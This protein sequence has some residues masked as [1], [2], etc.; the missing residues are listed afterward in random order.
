[1]DSL[2]EGLISPALFDALADALLL[3]DEAGYVI[4]SNPAAQKFLG[5]TAEQIY[6]LEVETLMPERFRS[7]HYQHREN[8]F[9]RPVKH[10][11]G[12]GKG[13]VAL[14]RDGEEKPM[15]ISLTPLQVKGQACVLITLFD[16]SLRQQ[17]EN[18]LRISEERLEGIMYHM[19]E[20][21]VTEQKQRHR[22]GELDALRS[23]QVAIQTATAIAHELNQ[24]LAAVS[25]YS[26]VA[27]H[28]LANLD[29]SENLRRALQGSAEQAQRAGKTLHE[30]LE[31]LH[32]G[33]FNGDLA[34]APIDMNEMVRDA[35]AAV[36]HDSH[37]GF[38][39]V[40]QL[41]H[42]LPAVMA[43]RIQVQ[44]I[45]T[46]LIHNGVEAARNA[47]MSVSTAMIRVQTDSKSGMA[48]ITVQDNG[49][50]LDA[51]MASKI[52]T[53]FFTT[54][55]RGIG[56][57]LAVSHALAKANGGKLWASPVAGPGATFYLTLPFAS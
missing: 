22:R 41:K 13:M 17:T 24:P 9:I 52:F 53:P 40:L 18:A 45:L 39:P 1:M 57:G 33:D 32:Q 19:T 30:L 20:R 21:R 36:Q 5:Y 28:E 27:L 16:A 12:C 7:I 31:F 3:A 2:F 4:A 55:L 25:A 29:C 38:H 23:Q 50:G 37:E 14:S 54:K 26:E 49:P 56:M 42:D 34:I 43:N 8:F 51:D 48:Q 47:G 44:S 35:I 10:P 6:G 15:D 46:N 11:M